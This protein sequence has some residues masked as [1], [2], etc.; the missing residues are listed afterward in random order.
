[1]SVNIA[2]YEHPLAP[3]APRRFEADS[4]A[5]WLVGHYEKGPKVNFTVYRGEPS[6]ETDVTDDVPT[7]MSTDPGEFTVLQSPGVPIAVVQIVLAVISIASAL[8]ASK[9]TQ[10]ENVNRTS[11]SS[12]NNLGSRDNQARVLQRVEDIYGTVLS[13]PSLMM[14]TYYKYVSHRKV[15]VG[16]YCVTRGSAALARI[17]DADTLIELIPGASAA[18]YGPFTSPNSGDAPSM[19]IGDP[20][21]DK[22]LTVSRSEEVD[23]VTLKARNQIVLEPGGAYTFKPTSTG[24]RITQAEKRPNFNSIVNPGDEI[25]VEMDDIVITATASVIADGVAGG[26]SGNFVI[27]DG[28]GG[29]GAGGGGEG[30]EGGEGE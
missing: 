27:S 7:L 12:N 17:R 16:Y 4:A 14:P 18:V 6:A 1:M 30:G 5:A 13:V 26:F 25:S 29:E 19:L 11:S 3:C 10:P 24:D 28:G 9:P 8:M 15:E 2:L 22:I 20:I 21:I 23:G